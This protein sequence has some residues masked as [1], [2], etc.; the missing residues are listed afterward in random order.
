MVEEVGPDRVG[1]Y[2]SYAALHGEGM[3]NAT[4]HGF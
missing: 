3:T 2:L 4:G 1:G